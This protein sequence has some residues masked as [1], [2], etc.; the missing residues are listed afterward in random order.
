MADRQNIITDY[1][2]KGAYKMVT[3]GVWDWVDKENC[4][5]LSRDMGRLRSQ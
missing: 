5:P 3:L 1:I 2:F 4:L